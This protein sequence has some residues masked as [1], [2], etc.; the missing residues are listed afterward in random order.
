[1][2][3]FPQ[4]LDDDNSLFLVVNNKRTALSSDMTDAVTTA[5]VVTTAGFPDTGYISILTGSDILN[6]EAMTYS[7]IDSTNFLNLGRGA[8]NTI[9]VPHLAEDDVDLTIVAAH[10]NILKDAVIEIENF[11]G[12]EDSKNFVPFTDGFNVILPE[13]LT[14]S[15]TISVGS[16]GD[17][18]DDVNVSGSLVVGELPV[19]TTPLAKHILQENVFN[20]SST[21]YTATGAQIIPDNGVN[22]IL[23]RANFGSGAEGMSGGD[24]KIT[25]SASTLGEIAS[26]RPGT[27]EGHFSDGEITGFKVVDTN[28]VSVVELFGKATS[29]SSS[30]DVG[31]QQIISIPLETMG[32]V[33]DTD[34][35]FDNGI[36]STVAITGS[37]AWPQPITTISGVLPV[38][39]DY[40]VFS[41]AEIEQQL[42]SGDGAF[43]QTLY[44]NGSNITNHTFMQSTIN[45]DFFSM[46][47]A[48]LVTLS[49]GLNVFEC[50]VNLWKG[51]NDPNARRARL[52]IINAAVFDQ[53]QDIR[54]F[55]DTDNPT[56][57]FVEV[58]SISQTYIPNQPEQVI[59]IADVV[60]QSADVANPTPAIPTYKI[61]DET[62]NVDYAA[63]FGVPLLDDISG[64][65]SDSVPSL[66]FAV[67]ENTFNPTDWKVYLRDP[68]DDGSIVKFTQGSMIIWGLSTTSVDVTSFTRITGD[69]ILSPDICSDE[70]TVINSGTLTLDGGELVAPTGTFSESLTVSGEPVATGTGGGSSTLQEAYDTG[71]GTISI[72]GG[73]PLELTGTGELTAV[74]G[75]FSSGLTVGEGS[76]NIFNESIT[77]GSGIFTDSL[78]VSGVPVDIT[79]GGGGAALTV[80]E[81]DG[82]PSVSN[83]DTIVVTTGTLT[84]DG[85]GQVTIQTGGNGG[86]G[87]GTFRG[88]KVSLIEENVTVDHNNTVTLSWAVAEDELDYDTDGFITAS[89]T[90]FLTVPQDVNKVRVTGQIIWGNNSTGSRAARIRKGAADSFSGAAFANSA[91]LGNTTFNLACPIVTVTGGYQFRMDALNHD[92]TGVSGSGDTRTVLHNRQTWFAIEVIE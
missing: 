45:G 62:D 49:A 86:G 14:V 36:D 68:N 27:T 60:S 28:G 74:T 89:G 47:R 3:N 31:A 55:A 38:A 70:L 11:L 30:I 8:G 64:G 85:G 59:V 1:M 61:V 84:D 50:T 33:E 72:T 22:L 82:S 71:D 34:Y 69:K 53:M 57:S 9:A 54:T 52:C 41:M 13:T 32:L 92:G 81:T 29:G 23:Y 12:T 21:S 5:N 75:T 4:T 37:I 42:F 48:S 20:I 58:S 44:I 66:A 73:K 76:T 87:A 91:A 2:V 15:G 80:K 24:L 6:T 51:T 16:E 39:G 19:N 65:T 88:A 83:V 77:T 78:T 25:Y 43:A 56:D 7:G 90:N 79:G 46:T 10:H 67:K 18:K 40:L 17:F 63:D 26:R 35:W